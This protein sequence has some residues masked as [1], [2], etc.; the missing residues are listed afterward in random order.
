MMTEPVSAPLSLDLP[1]TM[2][3]VDFV[4]E[5]GTDIRL[6]QGLQARTNLRLIARRIPQGRIVS[7]APDRPVDI[8]EGPVSRP[9]F[10]RFVARE[11]AREST[12]NRV[13]LVQGY[14]AA[15]AA[16]NLAGRLHGFPVFMLV[17]SPAEAYYRCRAADPVGGRPFRRVELAGLEALARLNAVIGGRYIVLSAYLEGI[18][19]R[20]RRDVRVEQ[21]PVYGVDASVFRP[22]AEPKQ[23]IRLELQL[24]SGGAL[25]F[26]SSRIAPEKDAE[27]LLAAV[28]RLRAGGRDVR[29]LHRSGGWRRFQERASALGLGAAVLAGDAVP[30]FVPLARLYQAADVCVQA[31]REEGLGFSPLEALACGVPVVAT[32]VGGLRETVIEGRTGWT[33]PAGDDGALADAIADVLDRPDEA[34]TRTGA[35]RMLVLSRFDRDSVFDRLLQIFT[36]SIQN[37][38]RAA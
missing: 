8:L 30:P 16:A 13:V 25:L 2:I 33:Y 14:G 20:H 31:S 5:S 21:V 26:F 19:R 12:G 29:V 10:A 4:V 15:A 38:R 34:Q 37:N 35:G 18:V 36:A 3:D 11:L 6:V 1:G 17:C 32:S 28:G 24:P 22:T 27:T 9:A 23:D 7:Q